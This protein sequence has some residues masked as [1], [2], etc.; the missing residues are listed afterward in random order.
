MAAFDYNISIT[1]DCTNTSSGIISLSL[2]GGTPP[3]TVDWE[4]P[5]EQVDVITVE[6]S[7]LTGL[8]SGVYAVRVNDSTLP[9]NEEFFI[10]IPVSSG[11]C[12][13]ILDVSAVT[14]GQNSG[15]VV[16]TSTSDFSSITYFL[17]SSDNVL[18]QSAIT[19]SDVFEF[20]G[21]NE[22]VYYII[23]EDIGGCRGRSQSFIIEQSE[24]IQY[25]LYVIPNTSCNGID[26]G[27]I[28]ITGLTG[29][30]PFNYVW[31]NGSA[32]S[33]ITGLT[34]GSYSVEVRDVNGCTSTQSVTVDRIPPLGFGIFTSTPPSCFTNDGEINLTI[35]GGSGPYYFSASTGAV[36]ITYSK[37]F[38]ISNLSAGQYNFLV[39]DAGLC[40]LEVGTNLSSPYGISSIFVGT[41]NSICSNNDGSIDISV[42]GGTSPYVY[43]LVYPNS[44]TVNITSL[45]NTQTFSNLSGGTYTVSIVDSNGCQYIEEV[46][47]ISENKFTIN[48]NQT[49]T[50]CGQNNGTIQ[51]VANEGYSLP[52]T[53]YLD[54]VTIFNNTSLSSI[55]IN[56]VS[57]GQHEV[58]VIDSEGCRQT[59]QIS[60]ES[61][62]GIN[63]SLF[64]TS[65]GSG[66]DGSISAFIFSGTPPYQFN[67]SNNIFGNPQQIQVSN[68]SGGTYSLTLVDSKGCS[69]TRSANVSCNA[70]SVTYQTYV[71]GE[72]NFIIDS[73]VKCSLSKMLND[74]YFNLISDNENCVLDDAVFTAKVSVNPLGLSDSVVFYSVT[75]LNEVIND[76]L[77]IDTITP[78]LLSVPGVTNVSVNDNNNQII[79]ETSPE[80]T[81]LL[82]QEIVL[83]LIINYNINCQS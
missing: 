51:V 67:W 5:I 41:N 76:S 83:E 75:S 39:T 11:V 81:T 23:G 18:I 62:S 6:P 45:I 29:N 33:S 7:I 27:K 40:T 48:V 15:S 82:N 13:D 79:I 31:S 42:F 54:G 69:L 70:N 57:S 53:Y 34:E 47:I 64:S 58:S 59:K 22:G 28:F 24:E 36:E 74:G 49:P 50:S 68:L 1:G 12:V 77:W 65:C 46:Y 26:N 2:L 4:F 20:S 66:S 17:Y 25:G 30:G 52:L 3:Y 55:T 37:T 72:Q 71:M 19:N 21:L 16:I 35:T 60:V 14:C 78:L 10:N 44:N 9:V 38:T 56:N 80:N 43:T 73:P 63:F 8:N 61:S 32:G